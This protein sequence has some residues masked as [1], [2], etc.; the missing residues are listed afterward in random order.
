M[1]KTSGLLLIY[2]HLHLEVQV[3]YWDFSFMENVTELERES[4]KTNKVVNKCHVK[5][6]LQEI[7]NIR[8]KDWRGLDFIGLRIL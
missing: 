3:Q 5:F 2:F 7:L 8:C 4:E 1:N 6:P